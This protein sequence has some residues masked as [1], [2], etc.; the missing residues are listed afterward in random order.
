[1]GEGEW[2]KEEGREWV[3]EGGGGKRI[4]K[5]EGRKLGGGGGD[6]KQRTKGKGKWKGRGKGNG[7]GEGRERGKRPCTKHTVLSPSCM[8]SVMPALEYS[9]TLQKASH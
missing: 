2:G 7:K 3:E 4:G 6:R 1:M 8:N 5:E 9:L